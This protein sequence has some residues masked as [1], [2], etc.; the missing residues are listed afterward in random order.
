MLR[1]SVAK[2]DSPA[3]SVRAE[4]LHWPK[5]GLALAVGAA[6][7]GSPASAQSLDDLIP[8]SA[9]EQPE[10]WAA[11]GAPETPQ[12]PA[13]ELDVPTGS[14]GQVSAP[15]LAPADPL[16]DLNASLDNLSIPE[17][18]ELEP[19]AEAPAFAEIDAPD[20]VELPDL[21]EVPL[22][23]ELVLALPA[24]RSIFPEEKEF[25]ERF[26][27]LSTIKALD[28]GQE[29]VPQLAARARSDEALL[30]DVLRN[31]GYYDGNVIRLLSGEA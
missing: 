20:L 11:Q 18:P 10:D 8:Q 4:R 24:D 25:V 15:P 17:I 28:S 19:D 6:M 22:G 2:T 26:R 3:N 14:D 5:L 21:I 12:S 29:S 27:A 31:Y 9:V 7:S 13:E 16:F 30:D 1:V 23:D